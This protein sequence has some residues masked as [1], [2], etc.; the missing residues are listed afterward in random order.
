MSGIFHYCEWRSANRRARRDGL[1]SSLKRW[2]FTAGGLHREK[3]ADSAARALE[4][5]ERVDGDPLRD[6][7]VC[8]RA[9]ENDCVA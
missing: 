2:E 4:R 9:G 3:S 1:R 8:R 7:A 6:R 5:D